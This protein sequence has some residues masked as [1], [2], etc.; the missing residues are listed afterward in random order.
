[1]SRRK[2]GISVLIA[3]QNEEFVIELCIRSFLEFGDELIVVDNGSTDRSKEIIRSLEA[4]FPKKIKFFDVPELPDLYHNR[5]FALE[6]SQYDWIFRA[7]ADYVAYTDGEYDIRRIREEMLKRPR[8]LRPEAFSLTLAN[9]AGDF[10]HTGKPMKPGGQQA[11]QD[12]WYLQGPVFTGN[13]R[14]YRWYPGMKFQRRGRWEGVRFQP[15]IRR[16]DHPRLV[17]MH[18]NLKSDLNFFFRSERTNWRQLGDFKRYPT[19]QSYIED[20]I[21][22]KYG[23]RD[24]N[25]A[26]AIY[27]Q[28]HLLPYLMP[29]DPEKYYPYPPLIEK[30]MRANPY[31][32]IVNINGQISRKFLGFTR[33][34]TVQ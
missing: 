10:W 3:C 8:S 13:L 4:E 32:K 17:C 18:V 6:R 30:Q 19:L 23:T 22:E 31:F 21:F 20:I 5:Q 34:D 24:V 2:H 7:D 11:N 25:E 14:I 28:K 27:M 29:Y 33:Y 16:F 9:L 15:L 12:R 26:A 1:M